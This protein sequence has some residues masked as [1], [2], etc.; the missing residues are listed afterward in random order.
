MRLVEVP[1][2]GCIFEGA[3]HPF[4]LSIGPWMPGFGQPMVDVQLCAAVFECMRAEWLLAVH[5]VPDLRRGPG[6][7]ARIGEMRPVVGQQVST[8]WTL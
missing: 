4:D 5:Q 7:A 6:L 1:F 2:D 8:M 3:V